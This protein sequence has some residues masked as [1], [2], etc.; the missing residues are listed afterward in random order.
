LSLG[1]EWLFGLSA[2]QRY[3]A[4]LAKEG[5]PGMTLMRPQR[6]KSRDFVGCQRAEQLRQ[7]GADYFPV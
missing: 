1:I 3:R 4:Q 5:M 6:G 7:G 2:V